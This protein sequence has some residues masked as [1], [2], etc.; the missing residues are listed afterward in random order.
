M[1]KEKTAGAGH[2][3]RV[4]TNLEPINVYALLRDMDR[5]RCQWTTSGAFPDKV[6]TP[7]NQDPLARSHQELEGHSMHQSRSGARLI[8][9]VQNSVF[10]DIARLSE[11][12]P[13]H[14]A[15]LCHV[16]LTIGQ[17][18]DQ[19]WKRRPGHPNNRWI[20]QLHRDNSNTPPA[21]LWTRSITRGHSGV[22]LRSSTTTHWR[23]RSW[24]VDSI[25]T[26][27]GVMVSSL[28]SVHKPAT[29]MFRPKIHL[30]IYIK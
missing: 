23:R 13:A 12:T 14:Q 28:V 15:L 6:P 16:D 25:L 1:R 18:A 10:G 3:P 17:F 24:L 5:T 21:D 27:H 26:A 7:N 2:T 11:D 20:D 29:F 8:T 19:T 4:R 22:M 9:C 30:K